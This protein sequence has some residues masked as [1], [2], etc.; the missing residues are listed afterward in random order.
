[1]VVDV[2]L[3]KKKKRRQII[4]EENKKKTDPVTCIRIRMKINSMICK[5]KMIEKYISQAIEKWRMK[6]IL[7]L[8]F[9]HNIIIELH[10]YVWTE[11]RKNIKNI[12]SIW[13]C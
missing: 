1:M 6:I 13:V 8:L 12:E 3:V 9:I 7:F 5:L 10:V 2:E 4:E 11:E